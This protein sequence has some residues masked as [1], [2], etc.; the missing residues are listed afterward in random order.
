MTDDAVTEPPPIED[1]RVAALQ[2]QLAELQAAHRAALLRAG[3]KAEALRAGMVDLDG[4]KLIDA[5]GVEL[6]DQGEVA[7]G[8]QVMAQLKRAK[9]WL[10]GLSGAGG[11]STSSAAAAPPAQAPKARRAQDMNY[12]EWQA[13]RREMVRRL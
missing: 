9:P 2:R 10:F 5:T 6:D 12:E 3:L 4:L 8:A 1:E 13:A 7:G 11:A